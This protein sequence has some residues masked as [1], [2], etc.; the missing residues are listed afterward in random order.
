MK[1]ART[2]ADFGRAA[3]SFYGS[4]AVEA[5]LFFGGPGMDRLARVGALARAVQEQ[6]RRVIVGKDAVV[7]LLLAA[8]LS[9]G[10][11]LIEDVPGIGKTML[12]KAVA[13]SLR[14]CLWV[15]AFST[16]LMRSGRQRNADCSNASWIAGSSRCE[17][18][19][20]MARC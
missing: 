14:A 20:V 10:H 19:V 4:D 6:I 15:R 8:L 3:D 12:A 17:M 11:V 5:F 13:R 9:E 16:T 2:A 18:S 1:L 7:E